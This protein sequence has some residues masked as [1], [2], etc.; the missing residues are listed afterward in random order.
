MRKNKLSIICFLLM[1]AAFAAG[2]VG[3]FKLK[4]VD[5]PQTANS[6][7]FFEVTFVCEPDPQNPIQKN[8]P[9][10][11]MFSA[12]IPK[13]WKIADQTSYTVHY[14]GGTEQVG[15]FAYCQY[16]SD[17][18][19]QQS[20][21]SE[22]YYWWGGRSIDQN[23]LYD[24]E[25]FTFTVKIYT[26][27]KTG[28]FDKLKYTVGD[29]T[30]LLVI[31]VVTD[32]YSITVLQGDQ[33]PAKKEKNWTLVY[34]DNS[35]NPAN[36]TAKYYHDEDF[37][38]YFSRWAGWNGG[39]VAVTTLLPDGR[40]VWTWGDSFSGFVSSNRARIGDI[41]SQFLRN[42]ASIQ[43]GDDF[44]SFRLL[45]EGNIGTIKPLLKYIKDNG[46]EAELNEEWYW[47]RGGNVYFRNGVP[48]LQVTMEHMISTGGGG[49]WDMDYVSCDVAVFSLPDLKLKNIVKD[50]QIGR[51]AFANNIMKDDDGIVYI[52]G[53][54]H[55]GYCLDVSFV[56]RNV[57]G[58][59]T[60]T[61]EFYNGKTKEWTTDYSFQNGDDWLDY[62]TFDKSVFVFK[63]GGNYFAFEQSP[64]FGRDSYIY[65]A[66]SPIGPFSNRRLV[67]RLPAEIST[68]S[69]YCYIP[70][71]HQQFSVNGEL[72]Y[73]ICKNNNMDFSANYNAPGSAESYRPYV[74]R[75]KNWRPDINIV[76]GDLTDSCNITVSD[77][78]SN[79]LE[80][81]TDNDETTVF[82]AQNIVNVDFST[83]NNALYYLKRYTITSANNAKNKDPL[84]WRL[85]G[86]VD[87]NDWHVLD[88]RFYADFEKRRQTICYTIPV[89]KAFNRFRLEIIAT[90]GEEGLQIAELQLFGEKVNRNDTGIA[91]I[92]EKKQYDND[93]P[94]VA[95]RYLTLQGIALAQPHSAGVYIVENQHKSGRKS[96]T[97]II[98]LKNNLT[99]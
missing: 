93:D 68:G 10:R 16:Y 40:S 23:D 3:C 59:L 92:R 86:S 99:N 58:D 76:E 98:K 73:S 27:G 28:V 61:W 88:E 33:I 6:N 52:Y 13:G 32:Y 71:T 72:V 39:D 57:D 60:G 12:H 29:D 18:V 55:N 37:Y 46:D 90:N 95:S 20:G 19:E 7:S 94:I 65:D 84:H 81:L 34:N 64:C 47:P 14:K 85:L 49:T 48:E 87:G 77:N 2:F 82:S 31:R 69:Y 1:T 17:Y 5:H 63:D 15:K 50:R 4:S 62:K 97:K 66:Q 42:A 44:A 96:A 22:G 38:G 36:P 9:S 79:T 70:A 11:G 26:D 78:A 45:N 51:I 24:F 43:D 30:D 53:H 80:K 91:L 89:C 41:A 8:V 74:Y 21:S 56:A 75:V 54:Q 67:G 83:A 35:W 25:Y